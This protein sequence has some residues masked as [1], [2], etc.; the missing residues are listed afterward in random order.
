MEINDLLKNTDTKDIKK[1]IA[2]LQVLVDINDNDSEEED[3]KSKNTNN[4][5]STRTSKPTKKRNKKQAEFVNKFLDMPEKDMH[6]DDSGIDKK[7]N[8]HPPVARAREFDPI[9]VMCRVCHTT[10]LVPPSLVESVSRYKCN[11]CA[12]NPG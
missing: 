11:K 7:L 4:T 12:K 2:L 3:E 10:E 1:L 6:K 9:E 8:V 5:K